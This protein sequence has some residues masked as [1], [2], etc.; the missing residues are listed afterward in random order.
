MLPPPP[1]PVPKD[2]ETLAAIMDASTQELGNVRFADAD[3]PE[4]DEGDDEDYEPGNVASEDGAE[5]DDDDDDEKDEDEDSEEQDDDLAKAESAVAR[6]MAALR[7]LNAKELAEVAQAWSTRPPP[8]CVGEVFACTACIIAG[9]MPT[10]E[11][12]IL[13]LL[14]EGVQ[15]MLNLNNFSGVLRQR[16]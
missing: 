8:G 1:A 9:I 3:F 5:S 16:Q 11:H 2:Y 4:E 7:S 15:A 10:I 14:F 13:V 6:A 12:K